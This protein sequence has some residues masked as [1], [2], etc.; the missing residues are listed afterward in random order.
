MRSTSDPYNG[1]FVNKCI[2]IVTKYLFININMNTYNCTSKS[3]GVVY[4]Y[5]CRY[6]WH[7]GALDS[8]AIEELTIKLI[9]YDIIENLQQK[10]S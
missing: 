7:E 6:D 5:V 3:V 4:I 9:L 2:K 1:G 8:G 10:K